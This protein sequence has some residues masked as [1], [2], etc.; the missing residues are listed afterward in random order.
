MGTYLEFK[1][2]YSKKSENVPVNTW[3]SQKW[4]TN[5]EIKDPE[6]HSR[7]TNIEIK[8]PEFHS[9][10]KMIGYFYYFYVEIYLITTASFWNS[11]TL[12]MLIA[13]Q[14][15]GK[16]TKYFTIHLNRPYFLLPS[17]VI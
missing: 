10:S 15:V 8:D 4:Q 1:R 5:I 13:S 11:T 2:K 6:F 12:I 7:S 9:Q 3:N 16:K 14:F 17:G